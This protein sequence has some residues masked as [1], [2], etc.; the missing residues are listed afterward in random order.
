MIIRNLSIEAYHNDDAI[1]NSK[2]SVFRECPLLYKKTYIDKTIER[3]ATKALDDGSAFD[4]LVFDGEKKF[5]EKYACKPRVYTDEKTGEE[6]KWNGNATACKAWLAI[7]E[8]NNITPIDADR[9]E[10]FYQMHRSM[11]MNPLVYQLLNTGESQLTLRRDAQK[12]GLAVQV[13]PDLFS[14]TPIDIPELGLSSNGRPYMCDLK[15]T[16]DFSDWFDPIDPCDPRNGSPV[17]KYNYHRQGGFAQWVAFQDVGE[18]DHFLIVAEKQEP[19]RCG[20]V[21]LSNDYLEL[22]WAACEADLTRLAACKLANKWPSS[23]VG[24]LELNP[25][26]FLLD[27]AAREAQAVAV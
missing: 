22:G 10:L 25:P 26:Q 13:R 17:W 11:M 16:A 7:Q 3:K 4:T 2:L 6:K 23:P 5:K 9:H 14:F 24:V 8:V 21:K 27:K 18:T 20:V 1:S 12:F 15:T 19:F